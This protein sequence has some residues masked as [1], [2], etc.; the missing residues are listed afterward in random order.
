MKQ[1][2]TLQSLE[3]FKLLGD[4]RRMDILRFLMEKPATLSQLGRRMSL[5]PAKVRYHLKLLEEAGLV[6]LTSTREVGS[7]IE[8]YY[9]S[10]AG[11]FF[12]N[13]LLLPVPAQHGTIFALGSHDPALELLSHHLEGDKVPNLVALPVGSL[14]G[15]IALKQDHCHMTGCHLFDPIS[16][17]YNTPYVRRIFP[18]QKMHLVTLVHREQGLMVAS[19]NP[20]QVKELEDLGRMDIT[21]VNRNQGSGTRLWFDHQLRELDVET[22]QIMGYDNEVST[23]SQV[24]EAVVDGDADV[25][26]GVMASA[27]QFQLDFIPLFQERFDLVIPDDVYQSELLKPALDYINT[28][29]FRNAVHELGGYDPRETGAEIHIL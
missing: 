20:Y 13:H 1:T 15:L 18:G 17:E 9:G 22:S 10:T 28:A 19:G 26:L 25:G 14:D 24:A 23:H 7:F 3:I 27:L 2:R 12:I 21:F 11:A 5:H 4:P 6:Q 16:G 8:K 29:D